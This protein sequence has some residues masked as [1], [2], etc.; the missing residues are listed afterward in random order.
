MPVVADEWDMISGTCDFVYLSVRTL[1]GKWLELSTLKL[2]CIEYGSTSTCINPEVKRSK[3][4][5]TRL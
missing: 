1:K 4:K 2:V 3:V 5:I